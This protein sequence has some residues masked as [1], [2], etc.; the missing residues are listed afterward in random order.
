MGLGRARSRV[1][2]RERKA[3]NNKRAASLNARGG[4][5][6][7]TTFFKSSRKKKKE[8]ILRGH[9]KMEAPEGGIGTALFW[10]QDVDGSPDFI[11]PYPRA[12]REGDFYRWHRKIKRSRCSRRIQQGL[13]APRSL[14]DRETVS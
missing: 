10:W 11:S 13:R 9:L 7:C 5:K 6:T 12:N 1:R 2:A 14:Q 4:V 8:K 3:G